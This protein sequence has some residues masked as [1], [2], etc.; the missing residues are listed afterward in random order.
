[1][2]VHPSLQ[3]FVATRQNP[4][5]YK[6]LWQTGKAMAIVLVKLLVLL[7]LLALEWT[8][9][10]SVS[11]T[12]IMFDKIQELCINIWISTLLL[13]FIRVPIFVE[14]WKVESKGAREKRV[15]FHS[16][17]EIGLLPCVNIVCY[18]ALRILIK[19]FVWILFLTVVST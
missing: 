17:Q 16:S 1:M 18:L 19:Y 2:L 10:S 6:L 5:N 14:C 4:G 11:R 3:I 7:D 12:F 8:I 9:L 15:M 13:G